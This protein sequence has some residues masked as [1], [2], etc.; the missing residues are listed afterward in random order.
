MAEF[1]NN[2]SERLQK[3]LAFSRELILTGTAKDSYTEHKSL[4][5]TVN[6]RETMQVTDSLLLEDIPFEQVRANIG[7]L[8][9]FF[10]K[11]RQAQ[12]FLIRFSK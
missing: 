5:D 10:Y 7:K 6:A 3:L 8:L 1:I 12:F 2:S 9:Y 4:L 11:S